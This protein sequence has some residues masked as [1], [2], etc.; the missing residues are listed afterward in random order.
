MTKIEWCDE[1]WNPIT[2]CSKVSEACEN[3]YAERMANRLK[4]RY[5][6]PADKPFRL[7]AHPE[8][9]KDPEKWK[10]PRRI[11]VCSMGDIFHEDVKPE[12]KQDVWDVMNYN[13]HHTFILLT[14]RPQNAPT[15]ETWWFDN[16]W[17][18]V[19]A[20]NQKRAD[21]RMP[22][23]LQIPAA[24][25]FVSVEPMLEPIDFNAIPPFD[26]LPNNEDEVTHYDAPWDEYLDW[27]ICGAETGPKARV[28]ESEWAEDLYHQCDNAGVPFFFKKQSK[29]QPVPIYVRNTR[30]FPK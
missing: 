20:E 1:T 25:R 5:G 28:M 29:S 27:V 19:T 16:I 4:G 26:L 24:V 18:G 2:G 30:E 8:R 6:Y 13:P 21:E 7:T 10:K 17:L 9:L 22:T 15:H 11:F 23:L 3:C 12:W 14:K